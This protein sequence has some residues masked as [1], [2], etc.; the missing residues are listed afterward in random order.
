VP[1]GEELWGVEIAEDEDAVAEIKEK[2]QQ[3]KSSTSVSYT[4]PVPP[5]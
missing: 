4:S 1:D 5:K 3:S 2:T